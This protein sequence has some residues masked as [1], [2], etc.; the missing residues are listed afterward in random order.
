MGYENIAAATS[1]DAN[2]VLFE[3]A[4]LPPLD[5]DGKQ[6]SDRW[7]HVAIHEDCDPDDPSRGVGG[8]EQCGE[9]RQQAEAHYLSCVREAALEVNDGMTVPTPRF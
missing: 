4:L 3:F 1:I 8:M 7:W 9:D 5:P 2:G 6:V